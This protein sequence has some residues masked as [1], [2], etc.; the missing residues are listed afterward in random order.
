MRRPLQRL[1]AQAATVRPSPG[2]CSCLPQLAVARQACQTRRRV[3]AK[4]ARVAL[5]DEAEVGPRLKQDLGALLRLDMMATERGF[6]SDGLAKEFTEAPCANRALT[7]G[8]SPFATA[9][10]RDRGI[11]LEVGG[12]RDSAAGWTALGRHEL[13]ECHASCAARCLLDDMLRVCCLLPIVVDP[14]D[15]GRRRRHPE[16]RAV[17]PARLA[18]TRDERS[19]LIVNVPL[20]RHL[21]WPLA[22]RGDP[23]HFG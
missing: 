12:P 1:V 10:I 21:L 20:G 16:T 13:D 11:A 5:F 8:S 23:V 19:E 17:V 3:H 9:Y 14:A 4:K 6:Q 2:W 7:D 15:I 22:L 18:T